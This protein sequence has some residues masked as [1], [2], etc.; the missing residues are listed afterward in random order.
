IKLNKIKLNYN[1]YISPNIEYIKYILNNLV[2]VFEEENLV[3]PNEFSELE[4]KLIEDRISDLGFDYIKESIANI[5]YNSFALGMGERG[6]KMDFYWL[7]APKGIRGYN[8]QKI[9][10]KLL[11]ACKRNINKAKRF[12]YTDERQTDGYS[13]DELKALLGWDGDVESWNYKSKRES[14]ALEHG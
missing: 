3:L 1:I 8:M 4:I 11:V 10:D 13:E 2:D 9:H 14:K 7:F 5:K 6:W 12:N